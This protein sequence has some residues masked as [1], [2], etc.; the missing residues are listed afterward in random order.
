MSRAASSTSSSEA[1]GL[2][3]S[4]R[5]SRRRL[6]ALAAGGAVTLAGCGFQPL[7]GPQGA[8]SAAGVAEP[9]VREV[10]ANTEVA[11]I[12]ERTGQLLRRALMERLGGAGT[13][14]GAYEL[15]V[16]PQLG[17]DFEGF[18]RDGSPSRV[19][20]TM[21]ASWALVSTGTPPATVLQGTERAFDAYNIPDN[22]FFAGD[23]SRDATFQ[24]L[25]EQVADDIM[26]RLAAGLR[27]RRST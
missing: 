3:A 20:N 21:T 18:R 4:P 23:F 8:T 24:R 25:I 1:M 6:M 5:P 2:T 14:H 12:P 26:V 7:Y 19:R 10:L 27:N 13:G 17:I 9:E 15:R 11:L 22:Q 16:Q